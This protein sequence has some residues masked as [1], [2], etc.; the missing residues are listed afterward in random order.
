VSWLAAPSKLR[1]RGV[2]GM[3]RRNLEFVAGHNNRAAFPLVDNKL[4]TKRLAAKAGI[5][6]PEL[7]LDLSYQFEVEA[8]PSR[9]NELDEFVIKPAQGSGGRGI[10]VIGGRD[11][12]RFV[13]SNGDQVSV[14]QIKRLLTNI[15]SGLHSLGGRSDSAI[16]ESRVQAHE[17]FADM[18]VD[19]VP[20]IRVIVFQGY[21]VMAMLRLGTRTSDGKANLHQGA[22]GVGLDIRT[23]ESLGAVR[24]NRSI[25]RHPDNGARLDQVRIPNWREL[26][27]RAS[28]CFDVTNLG[29]LG[30]DIVIDAHAGPLLL[31]MNAR[32]GLS[33][34]IANGCGLENRLRAVLDH[35][36][37][38]P[39]VDERVTFALEGLG[40]ALG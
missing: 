15:I 12:G 19:G 39:G 37:F 26:L 38:A 32:P 29:Y 31:E 13:K 7:I 2:V 16:I 25:T 23:G 6:T 34:Q 21:P 27:N 20:D 30:C 18:S 33:I 22:I 17:M 9:L 24:N 28:R 5:P 8:A 11:R 35:E 4:L 1:E 14:R 10:L 36:A 3:N 40:G